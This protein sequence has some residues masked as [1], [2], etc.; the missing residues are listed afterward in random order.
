MLLLIGG[1][2]LGYLFFNS[3]SSEGNHQHTQTEEIQIWTCSMHPQIK[4]TEPGDCPIC[5]ME[6]IP[7]SSSENGLTKDQ[8]RM[9]EN[10]QALANIQTTIIGNSETT[11]SALQLSGKIEENEEA[12]AIQSAYFDGRIENLAVNFKGEK[13]NRGQLIATIY[14]PELV[15]AQQEL[16]TAAK[17]KESQPKLYQAVRNKLKSWKLSENQINAIETSG[18]VKEN[19]P[20][21]SSVN[22]TVTEKMVEEGDYVKKGQP[23]VKVANL[24]NVW[25]V[26]DAYENQIE[27]LKKG[28]QIAI[29]TNAYP[30]Q[31]FEAEISFIDPV[32]N[33]STRTVTVRAELAN[34]NQLLKP[35]MFVT[36]KVETANQN[37]A[38]KETII[39]PKSAVLWTGERSIVYI[40]TNAKQPVFELRE[41]QLGGDL[42]ENYEIVNGLEIGDEIVTNG[43]FTVD[44]AAQLQGKKSMMN[45]NSAEKIVLTPA[46]QQVI[47]SFLKSYL[48][49]K[50]AFVA[51]NEEEIQSLSTK[52]IQQLNEEDF[53]AENEDFQQYFSTIQKSLQEIQQSNSI[54]E[55]RKFFIALSESTVKIASM[56]TNFPINLYI[57]K[58][59]MANNNQGARWISSEKNIKNP[60]FGKAMLTCG[61]VIDSIQ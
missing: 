52:I 25:A 19:F 41:V 46:K 17:S 21:Y 24:D 59:P 36:A 11:S 33:S 3:S 30:N 15:S 38:E 31:N 57:Q 48:T 12:N 4:K 7:A 37:S 26:F 9:T 23:I 14:A 27:T 34:K 45:Q 18:K 35:G 56:L 39:I 1:I 44:A 40:K 60:Y 22:G 43:T 20:I 58:C 54:E 13:I 61:S 29:K 42:G 47:I 32:L 49:L 55:Q 28:Q 50:D 16:L 8:F 5:G 10:A 53:S 51:S 2:F 6:L